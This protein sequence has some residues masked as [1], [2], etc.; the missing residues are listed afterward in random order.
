MEKMPHI[1]LPADLRISLAVLP[2]DPA[3]VLEAARELEDAEELAFSREYR[4]VRGRYKGKEILILSTGMGGPSTAI[5]VEELA[6][7]GVKAMVRI[8]SCGALQR[9]LSL[10]ELVLVNGAVC[11]D[12]TSRAYADAAY[13]AVPDYELLSACVESAKALGVPFRVGTGRSH[14]CL[15]GDHNKEIYEVWSQRGILASD[16]ETAAL[17]TVGALRKVKT[18]SILNVVA[19]YQADVAQSVGNYVNRE[20]ML[21]AGEKNEILTALEALV[22]IG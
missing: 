7:C 10:G 2:G 18:A 20:A 19:A 4:S 21:A 15:Y 22:R 11:D 9:E 1:G 14:D 6:R 16:M 12:G 13:P 3:R 17:F 8:G 5:A